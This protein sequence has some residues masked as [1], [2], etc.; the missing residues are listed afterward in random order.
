ML[1]SMNIAA[2]GMHAQQMTID[3]VANNL[4]NANTM[5][6]KKSRVEFEDLVYRNTNILSNNRLETDLAGSIGTGTSLL[7]L[8][9]VF[10]NGDLKKTERSLDLALQGDGFFEVLM[11]DGS[12]AYTRAGSLKISSDGYLTNLDGFSLSSLIQVPED[13][14]EL[15]INGKGE[16]FAELSNEDQPVKIGDIEISNFVNPIDLKPIGDNLYVPT[17]DSGSAQ[18]G[19]AGELGFAKIEQGYLEA[20]N[21]SLIEELTNLMLAQRAYEMN[22]KVIQASDELL[23]IINSLRR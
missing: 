5:G 14:N 16:V 3:V 7:N 17:N 18:Y 22:S 23:G 6:F 20:S 4:A 11:N 10:E 1:E 21:V 12:Y 8:G 13:A 15:I 9:K 2:T 19:T